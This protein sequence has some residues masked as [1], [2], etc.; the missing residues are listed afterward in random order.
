[1][2]QARELVIKDTRLLTRQIEQPCYFPEYTMDGQSILFSGS[3][4]AGLWLMDRSDLK[5]Q[6]ISNSAGAGYTPVSLSDG[7]I[8]HRQ[9]QYERGRKLTSLQR[10]TQ[11]SN[12]PLTDNIRF[13]SAVTAHENKLT[14]L[15][16]QTVSVFNV[17]SETRE[18]V[19]DDQ[20]AIFNNRLSLQLLSKGQLQEF[21]PLGGGTYIWPELSPQQD[22]VLFSKSGT[23]TFVSDLDGKILAE[24][25]M[26]RAPHWSPDGSLILYMVDID[27]GSHYTASEIWVTTADASK[28]W[29][30]T[31]TPDRIELY[32]NWS[33]RGLEIIYHTIEGELFETTLEIRD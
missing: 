5:V 29:Q 15:E 33:P 14:Y 4:Y 23:G 11:G 26:A 28:T 20:I 9:D 31:N 21:Q 8:I 19:S 3:G 7:S 16:D 12:Y 2:T 32:P 10:Y 27:D 25:G 13:L 22:K 24:L 1:M 17:L 18:S 30:I 6:Q